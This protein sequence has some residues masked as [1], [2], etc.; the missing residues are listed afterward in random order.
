MIV[1]WTSLGQRLVPFK[2][3]NCRV[4]PSVLPVRPGAL[5]KYPPVSSPRV[6]HAVAQKRSSAADGVVIVGRAAQNPRPWF[7][8]GPTVLPSA[9]V[10][11]PDKLAAGPP[12]CDQCGDPTTLQRVRK[13]SINHGRPFWLCKSCKVMTWADCPLC[14][15]GDGAISRRYVVGEGKPKEGK[16]FFSCA[17]QNHKDRCNF[18][19]WEDNLPSLDERKLS[20]AP[21]SST[22]RI[23]DA[24]RPGMLHTLQPNALR[25]LRFAV[26]CGGRVLL[27]GDAGQR[28]KIH[29]GMAV[30]V[31]YELAWPLLVV[32]PSH[33]LSAWSVEARQWLGP[34]TY[35]LSVRSEADVKEAEGFSISMSCAIITSYAML[36]SFSGKWLDKVRVV[37]VDECHQLRD[38]DTARFQAVQDLCRSDHVVFLCGFPSAKAEQLWPQLQS[39]MLPSDRQDS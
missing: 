27:I 17:H 19:A 7:S 4:A 28:R 8:S 29:L 3:R 36:H 22:G 33:L 10:V 11:F 16:F 26:S 38:E 30:A 24:L 21:S 5:S 12:P 34:T 25:A 31:Q 6:G 14:E 39:W 20:D 15:C 9:K 32:C 13:A 1:A 18:F 2:C 35:V 37:I 23:E